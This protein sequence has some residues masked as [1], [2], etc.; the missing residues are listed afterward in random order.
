MKKLCVVLVLAVFFCTFASCSSKPVSSNQSGNNIT[1]NETSSVVTTADKTFTLPYFAGDS[2]NPY[3]ATQSANFYLGSLM[4][5]C[6]YQLDNSFNPIACIAQSHTV[7]EGEIKVRIR[8]DIKFSDG[9]PVTIS[10]VSKS[11]AAAISSTYYSKRLSNISSHSIKDGELIIK[12]KKADINFIKNL[13]F[14]ITKGGSKQS[15][16]IGSGRYVL[17]Q[18][19]S[20]ELVKNKYSTRKTPGLE[21]IKL[22]EIHKYSTLSHMIKI[23]S[24]NFAYADNVDLTTAAIKTSPVLINNLVYL[25]INSNNTYLA[26]KDFRKA[27]SLCV[28][29]KKILADAYAGSGNATALPFNPI[30]TSFKSESYAIDLT[31]V[32]AAKEL[33]TISGLTEKGTDGFYKV[34]ENEK[35]SLRLLVNSENDAR[36][37]TAQYIKR[38]LEAQGVSIQI[39]SENKDAYTSKIN[40]GDYDLFLGEVKLTPDNNIE[41]LLGSSSLNLCND[42]G[43]SLLAFNNYIS[44]TTTLEDF[45]RSFDLNTVFIPL[46]YKNTMSVYSGTLSGNATTT[47]YDVFGSMDKWKF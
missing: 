19:G 14:P 27:L 34:N 11:L 21:S 23:G 5:D 41:A 16:A 40:S 4:Y 39:V 30:A 12:L 13:V 32:S 29:R 43:E 35:V 28:D 17:A 6:L 10:D 46:L 47:E 3:S 36:V 7:N 31:N 8:P 24:V 26:N 9:T 38:D 20:Y 33:F 22:I 1:L 45:L 37:R 2:L 25:G 42:N 18:D 15:G 44:G